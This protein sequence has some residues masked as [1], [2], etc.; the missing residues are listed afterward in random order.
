[1]PPMP[2][3]PP[4]PPMPPIGGAASFFGS[5]VTTASEVM[6]REE[7]PAASTRAVRT[8]LVGS[9]MP[10][11]TMSVYSPTEESKPWLTS[12][13]LRIFWTMTAPSW[14]ALSAICLAGAMSA[15]RTMLMPT[16]WSKLPVLILSSSAMQR[17]SAHPPPG[18]MPSST[19]ARVALSASVTRSFF[20]PTSTSLAPPTLMMATPPAR[21]ARRSWNF[22]FSY[23]EVVALAAS[24]IWL[25]R[26]SMRSFWPAPPM[27]RVSSLVMLTSL[28]WPSWSGVT[29]SSLRSSASSPSTIPPVMTAISCRVFLRLSPKPGALTAATCSWP[30]S[31]FT[32]SVLRASP[33]TSSATMMRGFRIWML[34]SRALTIWCTLLIFFSDR[35]T[36]AFWNST[37][38]CLGLLM[39]K[40]EM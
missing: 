14:P 15:L 28:T 7:T 25:Q 29:S 40:G 13:L 19:A 5:S 10:A 38:W 17:S 18:T 12:D 36:K 20:S 39:K 26:S 23:S 34:I 30:R 32:T 27:N 22:S 1:M 16:S 24:L 21:R 8:T 33:S 11:L 3:I 9:I 6:R 35:S 37:F 2:P 4:I 31:L